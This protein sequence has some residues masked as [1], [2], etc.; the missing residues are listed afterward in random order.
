MVQQIEKNIPNDGD[1]AERVADHLETFWAFGMRKQL[2]DYV[3]THRS[4]FGF[5]IQQAVDLLHAKAKA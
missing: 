3:A 5:Q 2:Y 1:V 4:E